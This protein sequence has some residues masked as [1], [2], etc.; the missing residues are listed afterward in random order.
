MPE[1]YFPYPFLTVRETVNFYLKLTSNDKRSINELLEIVE[2]EKRSSLKN[3]NLSRGERQRLGLLQSLI[4]D[5]EILLL[6]EPLGGLDSGIRDK[7]LTLL[8][9]LKQ[10]EKTIIINSHS[11][12]LFTD[13]DML[14]SLENGRLKEVIEF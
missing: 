11:S 9:E 13:A 2:L 4:G 12:N 3:I 1:D 14:I 6:D 7:F 10:Q 8:V 5:P